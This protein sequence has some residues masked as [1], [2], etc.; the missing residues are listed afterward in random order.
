MVQMRR[1]LVSPEGKLATACLSDAGDKHNQHNTIA[2]NKGLR[3][4]GRRPGEFRRIRLDTGLLSK[5]TGSAYVEIGNTICLA[6]VSG[7]Q[8]VSY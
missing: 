6:S 3:E 2:T 5:V 8:E 7:P 4:D 1:E